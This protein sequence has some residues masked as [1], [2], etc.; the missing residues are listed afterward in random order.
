M[1]EALADP[2]CGVAHLTQSLLSDP[3]RL[4]SYLDEAPTTEAKLWTA[5]ASHRLTGDTAETR[6]IYN[7]LGRPRVEV[8]GLDDELRGAILHEYASG[9]ERQ[10]DPRW[11]IE[12]LCTESPVRP[13]QDE[14]LRRATVA[15]AAAGLAPKPPV[16]CGE[17]NHRGGG[18]YQ[19]IEFGDSEVFI[20]TLGR[21]ATSADT[22]FTARQALEPAGFRWIDGTTGAVRVTDLCVYYFGEREPLSVDTLLF[23]WQD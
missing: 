12:A 5:Y 19:V 20:S 9:C 10:S 22:D 13:D 18:T 4:R 2:D 11:R 3:R 21:F 7:T 15:L 16:F 23:Y 17:H 6:A 14:Q 8:A 1:T